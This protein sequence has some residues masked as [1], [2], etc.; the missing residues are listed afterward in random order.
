MS[1]LEISIKLAELSAKVEQMSLW[2]DVVK[3]GIPSTVA[4][5]S[6]YLTYRLSISNGLIK[7][8]CEDQK[9]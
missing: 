2:S 9:N 5:I 6:S 7:Y 3:V 4:I 8:R 1:E